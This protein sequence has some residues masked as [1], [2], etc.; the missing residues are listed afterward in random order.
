MKKLL[1]AIPD[2]TIL[3]GAGSIS[4]GAWMIYHPAGFIVGGIAFVV[5]GVLA[6]RSV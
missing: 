3:A 1:R 6:A 4:F 2:L 5:I